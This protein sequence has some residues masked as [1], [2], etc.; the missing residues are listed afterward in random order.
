MFLLK[1]LLTPFTSPYFDAILLLLAGVAILWFTQRQRLG[2]ILTTAAAV[3][4]LA[5]SYDPVA[6]LFLAPLEARYA[7]L[8]VPPV[9]EGIKWVV[10]LGGGHSSDPRQPPNNQLSGPALG[11]LVEGIRLQRGLPGSRLVLSGGAV[12][13][14]VPHARILAE[15]AEALGVPRAAIVTEG[16]SLDTGDEAR[17]IQKIV[18]DEPFVLVTSAWHLPRA[19]GL[20]EKRG[21]RPRPAPADPW[22]D[23]DRTLGPDDFFPNPLRLRKVDAAFHEY[24][25]ILFAKLRGQL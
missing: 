5:L 2:K 8:A 23:A 19:V 9:G 1:K 15:T 16:T 12:F 3:L 10:V 25:G 13:D 24:A 21:M 18:R 6:N 11:R 7:P 20:F 17:A 22:T 4:L 14:E